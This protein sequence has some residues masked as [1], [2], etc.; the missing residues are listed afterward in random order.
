[1]QG[2]NNFRDIGHHRGIVY[3]SATLDYATTTD[4]EHVLVDLSVKTII[5]LRG[6]G[7]S[8]NGLQ[9]KLSSY[10]KKCQDPLDEAEKKVYPID[11]AKPL[12]PAIIKSLPFWV[13]IVYFCASLVGFKSWGQRF[14]LSRSFLGQEGLLGLNKGIIQYCGKDVRLI[15]DILAEKAAYPV[16]IHCSAGK[17]RTGFV[18]AILLLL[19]GIPRDEIIT[20]YAKSA[21]LLQSVM[22][23]LMIEV[24]KQGLSPEFGE[25]PPRV[26][27]STIQYIEEQFGNVENYLVSIGVNLQQQEAIR[28]HLLGKSQ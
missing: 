24:G 27:A 9:T 13:T 10:Y 15:M 2:V 12:K 4:I 19:C 20:D 26:M 18:I 16:I 22:G 25:S 23:R 6:R 5:D 7:E 28:S 21:Q 3:R 8:R 11:L 14:A 1:M 17:D